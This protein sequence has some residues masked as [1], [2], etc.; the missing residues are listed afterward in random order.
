MNR[1]AKPPADGATPPSELRLTNLWRFLRFSRPYWAWLVGGMVTGMLRMILPMYMPVFVKGVIDR[2]LLVE[3]VSRD[4]RLAVLG[5]LLLRLAGLV[6]LHAVATLG[7][8]YCPQ[9]AATHAIRDIRHQLYAHLQ[10]L[11][12]AFHR[13][14][15]TGSIVS[16]VTTD[17][18]T[19]QNVFDLILIQFSQMALEAVV[20][21]GYLLYR[22]WVWALVCLVTL[23]V[24]AVVTRLV[25]RP[26]RRA[27]RQVL[28]T[29]E[30][31]SGRIHERMNMIRE[32]QAFTAEA[33][34]ESRV[35]ADVEQLAT[36]T[37][38]QTLLNALLIGAS[39]I[40]RTVALVI[41]LGFGV[42]RV[43]SGHASVGDVT[44]FYLYAGMLLGPIQ[45]MTNVYSSIHVA[46]AAADR[47]FD[48]LDT[49]PIIRD[50]P[51]ALPLEA[52]RPPAVRFENVRFCY[53]AD[54]PVI[55]L[56]NISFEAPPGA[57]I[58]L[59]G[60]SGAG[61]STLLSLLPRFYDIQSGRI[62]IDGRDIRDVTVSSLRRAVGI[63]PQEAVLFAG[64][65]R[66]NILY[67][68]PTA[69]EAE[70]LSA[71]AAANV[72]AFIGEMPRGYDTLVGERGVG[73]SGG[74]VQRIALARAFLKDPSVL[75]LDEATS[76]LDALAEALVLEAIDRLARGRTTF[77][78][79][80][81]LSVARRADM[82]VA[83]EEGRI[84]ETG[85]HDELLARGGVYAR[86]WERQ[87][88]LPTPGVPPAD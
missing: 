4:D 68:R 37:R 32:V 14:R 33:A 55:V 81:R 9:V 3:G 54:N 44:A 66:E 67:G 88:G 87:V 45:F 13:A 7:R 59:V 78:I 18:S 16:R 10:R 6:A 48:F 53:P 26:M 69:S 63:V 43:L 76:N 40:T 36:H 46:S 52:R 22:D 51:G 11:S 85:R 8:F 47:V 50:A 1:P 77:I 19:A 27:S 2:V 20:V 74:Q 82:I 28:E 17:V 21:T 42:R 23:P 71:A 62:L 34:E 49:E 61:K 30:R 39:E 84:A 83:L 24:F 65:I 58:V 70:M 25:S 38:R 5:T 41:V 79:A 75:I 72:E 57:R 56:D 12:L 31:M 64:T 80:H 29:F 15:P 86:L 60:E 73:L 35:R